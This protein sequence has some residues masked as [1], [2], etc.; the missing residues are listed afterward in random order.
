MKLLFSCKNVRVGK[1]GTVMQPPA[2][3]MRPHFGLF[4]MTPPPPPLSPPPHPLTQELT[5]WS[6]NDGL[7]MFILLWNIH[8][9]A[10]TLRK[11]K[12]IVTGGRNQRL[13]IR[14]F[15]NSKGNL[16]LKSYEMYINY[17]TVCTHIPGKYVLFRYIHN[18]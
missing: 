7:E 3:A 17:L 16:V 13:S 8:V 10:Y 2:F 4:L 11:F 14:E 5:P 9:Q 15:R 18:P 6:G 1:S 12:N